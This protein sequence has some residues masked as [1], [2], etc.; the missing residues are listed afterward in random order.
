MV[1]VFF[2][3]DETQAGFA[4]QKL[5]RGR[6]PYD[7][8]ADNRDVILAPLGRGLRRECRRRCHMTV[9]DVLHLFDL[10]IRWR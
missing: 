5:A 7:S 1:V 2:D 3:D 6:Q 10:R 9:V 8:R 4:Q